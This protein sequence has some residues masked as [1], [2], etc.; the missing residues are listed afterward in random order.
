MH[1]LYLG[2]NSMDA[3]NLWDKVDY[4]FPQQWVRVALTVALTLQRVFK[5][6]VADHAK[7]L[8]LQQEVPERIKSLIKSSVTLKGVVAPKAGGVNA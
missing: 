2:T 3:Q 4:G 1:G 8:W 6:K 7:E 5:A